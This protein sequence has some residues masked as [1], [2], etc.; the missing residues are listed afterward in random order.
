M[1]H[2]SLLQTSFHASSLQSLTIR[3]SPA[4]WPEVAQ[5][6]SSACIEGGADSRTYSGRD[7]SRWRVLVPAFG[8]ARL[9]KTALGAM[10]PGAFIPPRINTLAALLQTLPP[11]LNAPAVSSASERLMRLYA[12]LRQHAWLKKIF[13]ARRNTDLLPLAQT[14]LA[15]SDEL[16]QALLPSIREMALQE[17]SL[18]EAGDIA[19]RWQAALEQLTPSSRQLLS[20][21]TQL[22]WS[23]WKSQLDGDD[24]L[25]MRFDQMLQFAEQ[26]DSPLA[27]ISSVEPEPM[28]RAF[29]AA[30]ARRQPVLQ[31]SLDWGADAVASAYATAWPE[32]I[33]AC[34]DLAESKAPVHFDDLF[35]SAEF[36]VR[37]PAGI[38]LCAAQ[39][40]EDEAVQGAQ[41]ILDWLHAGKNQ[42]AIV[43]QD[44]VVARR[45]R[46]LL[47]RAQVHVS[48][49][50]GWKLSTTRAAS[51]IAA[52]FD[53]V[54]Q[55]GETTA[56][57]DFLKSPFVLADLPD[58][59]AHVMAIEIA[60]RRANVLGEW[61]SVIYALADNP[62]AQQIVSLLAQQAA[63]YAGRKTL[64]GWI[65]AATA[66]QA[67][68]M[69]HALNAD[70]AGEQVLQ[71][72]QN[73]ASEPSEQV[74]GIAQS[75]S[76][77][78]LFSF[79]EWRALV[80]L[81]M[82]ETSF[83]SAA[84]DRR[85]VMLPL[86]GARLRHFDAV[87]LVGAD[88]S[89]LPSQPQETLFFANTVRREL[90]LATRES[91][92]RQ[93]MRD[94]A[95]LLAMSPTVVLSWQ[96]HQDGE[97]NPVSPWIE[98]LELTLARSGAAALP[99]HRALITERSLQPMPSAMPAPIASTLR[100]D[101]LSASGYNSFVA[102]PYQFFATR[103]LRLTTLDELSD[104]P[105]KRDYGGWLHQ[106]LETYHNTV[107]DQ[108][109]RNDP[110]ERVAL[111]A[112]ISKQLFDKV[113]A[114]NAAALGYYARWQKVISAYVTWACEREV[115]G[116]NFV[117]GEQAYEKIL[118]LNTGVITLHGRVDRIDE[119]AAGERAVLDY[120]SNSVAVLN[121]KLKDHEDHQLAFYGLL[122]D[123]S[124][125][126]A[127]YVAL[128]TTKEKIGDV[129]AQ[130]YAQAQEKLEAHIKGTMQAISD[131][132]PLPA[133]GIESICQYCDVRGLCRKGAW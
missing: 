73:I 80:N 82:D 65:N 21:E 105:E 2:T 36:N 5:A 87:L 129:A 15:L 37:L 29:L 48:D 62:P 58:K 122:S 23:I 28:E 116:W 103:M 6:L 11:A 4:F 133:N 32:L 61:N 78:V 69:E 114:K 18:R 16:T 96:A 102:C 132:A 44:R 120:K 74:E 56:L 63:I 75:S 20:D 59:S 1:L 38:A 94:L 107:R 60:L 90:D 124:V 50:T 113:I 22:V 71:M 104:L 126:A 101:R 7:L 31:I 106:I 84:P 66:L 51:A 109:V 14:L 125:D 49:E 8:H 17:P 68:G 52:W 79:P 131:S 24:G 127:L 123:V 108:A 34:N 54:T 19:Q 30:Y 26:A 115:N 57:L 89:H 43:A 39:S 41:T 53:V 67:L 72:L 12:E 99:R 86:N 95:E 77:D 97:P 100:P 40:I 91:R 35:A 112:D 33:A 45:I 93:Q 85:V 98:R 119:N 64:R 27:W 47:E 76:A 70:P 118:P 10:L 55:R 130:D 110:V 9:L 88:S 117:L 121:K 42:L 83:I 111:L 81:Q 13:S 92:Q 25:A 3:P 128:E 46:A